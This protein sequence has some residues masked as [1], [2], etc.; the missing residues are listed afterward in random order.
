M[1][2]WRCCRRRY[3]CLWPDSNGNNIAR[4]SPFVA[5]LRS[6]INRL[7]LICYILII[8]RSIL[9][10]RYT[11]NTVSIL[12][13]RADMWDIVTKRRQGGIIILYY[14]VV[15]RAPSSP[16]SYLCVIRIYITA[17]HNDSRS[18]GEERFLFFRIQSTP[19]TAAAVFRGVAKG[20]ALRVA[21][22]LF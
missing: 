5:P 8:W 4:S 16:S 15:S 17:S 2:W 12:Y 10:R 6:C 22:V 14:N 20:Y 7:W 1:Q 13:L 21:D 11:S 3:V 19:I 9:S 18:R